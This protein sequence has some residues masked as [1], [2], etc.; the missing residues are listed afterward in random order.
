GLTLA[1]GLVVDDAIVVVENVKRHLEKSGVKPFDATVLAMRETAG[2]LVATALVL[3]SVFVPVA[4][5]PGTTGQL[6]KQFALTIAVSVSLSAFN[7]LTLSPAL[8]ALI[9]K[10][11]ESSFFLFV[12]INK[13]IDAVRFC[14]GKALAITL[15]QIPLAITAAVLSLGVVYWLF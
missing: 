4:F 7:A 14:Y 2:A 3:V 1:T 15:S 6:Y 8:A 5:M 9:L 13:L 10:E 12:W 11:G